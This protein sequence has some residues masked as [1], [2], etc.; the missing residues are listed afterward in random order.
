M[1]P[2]FAELIPL[3]SIREYSFTKT[4]TG[5]KLIKHSNITKLEMPK[6]LLIHFILPEYQI[7]QKNNLYKGGF[8][9]PVQN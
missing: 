9:W 7:K 4:R 1:I 3:G 8:K 5:S 6:Y 2:L